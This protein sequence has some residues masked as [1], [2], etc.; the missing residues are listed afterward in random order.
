MRQ[1]SNPVKGEALLDHTTIHRIIIVIFV[2]KL[3]GFWINAKKVFQQC[4]DSLNDSIS[5]N[6]KITVIDNNSCPEIRNYLLQSLDQKKIDKLKIL[7]NNRGK[8]DALFS[9]LYGCTEEYITLTDS[10]IYFERNWEKAVF[11]IFENEKRTALVN[12][13]GQFNGHKAYN[14]QTIV[15]GFLSGKID[16]D[17]GS[18]NHLAEEY[19]A[20]GYNPAFRNNKKTVYLLKKNNEFLAAI[21]AGHSCATYKRSFL[22][23]IPLTKVKHIFF[24][25]YEADYLDKYTSVFGGYRLATIT[26]YAYHMGDSA[27]IAGL[28]TEEV[29]RKNIPEIN[30][31]KI[32]ANSKF[33][34]NW[35]MF[36][37]RFIARVL[38]KL[39]II[40]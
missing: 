38:F 31:E 32:L 6:S 13:M 36:L 26:P 34:K 11:K 22:R 7:G 29:Y 39:K 12:P 14:E 35:L 20:K 30:L 15:N 3:E 19:I 17:K 24:N 27:N 5:G 33:K 10:D 37:N 18:I 2:P 28:F 25:G 4:L 8:L 1:G 23:C 21:G 40:K 16:L 9:E